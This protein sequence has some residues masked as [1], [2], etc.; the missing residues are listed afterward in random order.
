MELESVMATAAAVLTAF[1]L[2]LL[3]AI[4]AWIVGRF[5]IR[6]AVRLMSAALSRQAIDSMRQAAA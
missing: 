1:G 2:K 4:S 5:L 6:L 3:G